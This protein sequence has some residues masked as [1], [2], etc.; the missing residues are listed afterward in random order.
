MDPVGVQ[1][2]LLNSI[3]QSAW[4]PLHVK[5]TLSSVIKVGVWSIYHFNMNWDP[6]TD[7]LTVSEDVSITWVKYILPVSDV[8][9]NAY[10]LFV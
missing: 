10:V 5:D 9:A 1:N 8:F 6:S 7:F 2:S 3:K 4:L